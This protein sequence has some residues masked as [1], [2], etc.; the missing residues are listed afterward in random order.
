MPWAML[1]QMP[2]GACKHMSPVNNRLIGTPPR[3]W[4]CRACSHLYLKH[5]QYS[6]GFLLRSLRHLLIA[7]PLATKS[8]RPRW[9]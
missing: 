2:R 3:A 4:T 5:M 1:E 8:D 9:V 6:H 7:P